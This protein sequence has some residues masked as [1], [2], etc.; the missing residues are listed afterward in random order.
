M[1]MAPNN[2][3]LRLVSEA[4]L[5]KSFMTDTVDFAESYPKNGKICKITM[6]R[7]TPLMNPEITG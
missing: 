2:R 7:P 3:A 1:V 6:I 5:G 4:I